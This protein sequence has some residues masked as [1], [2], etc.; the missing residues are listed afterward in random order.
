MIRLGLLLAARRLRGTGVVLVVAGLTLA[1]LVLVGAFAIAGGLARQTGRAEVRS[2]ARWSGSGE[3][4]WAAAP[5]TVVGGQPLTV[6]VSWADP[7][8]PPVF[9]GLPFNPG[10]G[11]VV[12]SPVLARRLR[13]GGPEE[14]A[15]GVRVPGQVMGILGDAALLGPGELVAVVG[16]SRPAGY[17]LIS[18][19]DRIT[20]SGSAQL[21]TGLVGVLLL[22]PAA[23]LVAT[24]ARFDWKRRS[25]RLGVLALVGAGPRQLRTILLVESA[26]AAIPAA[27]AG[28]LLARVLRPAAGQVALGTL[29]FFPY[30]LTLSGLQCAAVFT[31]TAGLGLASTLLTLR[32]LR[33]TPL[34]FTT[35]DRPTRSGA[36]RLTPLGV[37]AVVLLSGAALSRVVPEAVLIAFEVAGLALVFVGLPIA[38]PVLVRAGARALLRW[39]KAGGPTVV[40]ARRLEGDPEAGFRT[41]SGLVLA[42]FLFGFVSTLQLNPPAETPEGEADVVA[43]LGAQRVVGA[44]VRALEPI[45][46]VHAVAPTAFVLTDRGRALAT[47]CDGLPVVLPGVAP[48]TG[49]RAG[50]VLLPGSADPEPG[51]SVTLQL[52]RTTPD[53][54]DRELSV[55]VAGRVSPDLIAPAELVLLT[56]TEAFDE[57][58]PDQLLVDTDGSAAT[59]QAV[60]AAATRAAPLVRVDTPESLA[61]DE[62]GAAA[63]SSLARL[64]ISF[65]LTLATVTVMIG[66]AESLLERRQA[67][68]VLVALGMGPS[69]TRTMVRIEIALPLAVGTVPALLLGA[70]LSLA[71]SAL[72]SADD[73]LPWSELGFALALTA[74]LSLVAAGPLTA[75][76]TRLPTPEALRQD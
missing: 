67:L 30:D 17:G 68:S 69:H 27:L 56:E 39:R 48:E 21:L 71:M 26:V 9:A 19:S 24:S 3:P 65:A 14:E 10:Q 54:R 49:C 52:P 12:A 33:W 35:A 44:L 42:A 4:P 18:G 46:G 36:R 61:A 43:Q 29:R 57:F 25:R 7:Q 76:A 8:D 13:D 73:Q 6:L 20:S 16:G 64:V 1:S 66:V 32:R 58:E 75:F 15:F 45:E 28:L 31:L 11:E 51:T 34:G 37:G 55:R 53:G 62:A 72:L 23:V 70:G 59:N 41:A 40:A 5:P 47:T 38:G 50:A 2:G 22:V 60:I 74:G 63:L